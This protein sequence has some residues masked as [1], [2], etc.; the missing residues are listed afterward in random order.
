MSSANTA[1]L[2]SALTEA[3]LEV[4][5]PDF[6][7][8]SEANQ[9]RVT[10][11]TLTGLMK[12]I[13]DKYNSIDFS[14]IEKSA[15]DITRF[16][17]LGTI[18]ENIETLNNIYTAS[19]DPG[20]E[21]YLEV[22][23][24]AQSCMQHLQSYRKEYNTLYKQGNGLIQL[25]YVS[26][27]SAVIYSMGALVSNTIRFVTTE[28]DTECQVLFDEIP[29]AIKNIHIKNLLAAAG[30]IDK[31]SKVVSYYASNRTKP[32]NE[33]VSLVAVLG[34]VGAAGVVIIAIPAIIN[35]IREII[36]SIYYSR[37]RFSEMLGVQ[38]D[39]LQTNI[40]SLESGRGSKIV[41]ARQKR[42]VN[43][44]TKWMNKSA[45]KMDTTEQL[46]NVQKKKENTELK[47]GRNS[48]ANE[49]IDDG[50]LI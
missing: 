29:N 45:I 25:M 36:Y 28:Q 16:K 50:I 12:F 15:G 37:M 35:L 48:L 23:H 3:G 46:V 34:A 17:Y 39:L 30:S 4:N 26:M 2:L 41:V 49:P 27:V 8:M 9:V 13:T 6:M 43:L 1:A 14:E 10:D 19:T 33:S 42:I 44:L 11:D 22:C 7:C 24:A 32:V 5:R 20:A 31:Y 38:I 18:M 21:K 40:E 47:I